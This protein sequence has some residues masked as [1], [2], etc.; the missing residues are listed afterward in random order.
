MNTKQAVALKSKDT[1]IKE[2]DLA[3]KEKEAALKE[4]DT[5]I[6]EMEQDLHC[7]HARIQSHVGCNTLAGNK[8]D[9]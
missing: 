9:Q 3:L 8:I 7:F 1:T 6:N 5:I 2:K 4:K